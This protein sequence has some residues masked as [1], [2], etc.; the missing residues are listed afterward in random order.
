MRKI[1]FLYKNNK[2]E[3]RKIYNMTL[4]N[5]VTNKKEK[6]STTKIKIIIT[7]INVMNET[8]STDPL[9]NDFPNKL[10]PFNLKKLN[11]NL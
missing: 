1:I 3:Q 7:V 2:I 4:F 10:Y 5:M 9:V 11:H 8:Q 6:K